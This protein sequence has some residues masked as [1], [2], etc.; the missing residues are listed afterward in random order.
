MKIL[1]TGANGY[2]GRGIVKSLLDDGVDVVATDF[3]LKNVDDRATKI[4]CDLFSIKDPY[5]ELGKPGALLHLAWRDG[6]KHASKAHIEDFSK[7]CKFIDLFAQSE[8]KTISVMG[9]MHEVG[10]YEGAIDENTPC[11]P[12]NFYGIA[13]NALREVTQIMC[14]ENEKT[15]LWLR[16]F[17]I[18]GN[19]R[20]GSSIFAKIASAA[21][22]NQKVFPFTTGQNKCDF[23]NYDEFCDYVSKAV[24]QSSVDGIVNI[25]SGNPEKLSERVERFIEDNKWNIKLE[26]GAF[27][28]RD[29]DSKEVWGN[30]TKLKMIMQQSRKSK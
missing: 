16:G 27:P 8:I 29:Y 18:V 17:Y 21:D 24:Q 26:Y 23:L 6:F 1:V 19:S 14:R 4:E 30:N 10:K 2:L 13:K 5:A 3:N 22:Q 12:Q 15:F 9:S 20:E 7:H 11:K 25:C 28:E